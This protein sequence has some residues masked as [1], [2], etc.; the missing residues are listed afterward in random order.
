MKERKAGKPELEFSPAQ[1]QALFRL[2]AQAHVPW[3]YIPAAMYEAPVDG[4]P[5][6]APW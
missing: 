1:E 2:V 5:A 4:K 3:K 6:F